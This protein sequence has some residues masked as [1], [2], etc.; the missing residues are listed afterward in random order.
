MFT[1]G[2]VYPG[3]K[4]N[5]PSISSDDEAVTIHKPKV[6]PKAPNRRQMGGEVPATRLC[7]GAALIRGMASHGFMVLLLL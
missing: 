6:L 7:V 3:S 5:T 1:P 2:E 4:I